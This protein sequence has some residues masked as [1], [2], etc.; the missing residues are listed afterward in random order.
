[1]ASWDKVEARHLWKRAQDV[2]QKNEVTDTLYSLLK[3]F[4]E[5]NYE[6]LMGYSKVLLTKIGENQELRILITFMTQ[7]FKKNLLKFIGQNYQNIS[8]KNFT[9]LLGLDNENEGRKECANLNWQIDQDN[10]IQINKDSLFSKEDYA[11]IRNKQMENLTGLSAF[12]D[13]QQ[14]N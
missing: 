1:M 11:R 10:F 5:G 12:L 2:F 14:Q 3:V 9:L 6:Q 8:L 4:W 13:S 7:Q